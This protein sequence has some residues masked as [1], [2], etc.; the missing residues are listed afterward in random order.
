MEHIDIDKLKAGCELD[1]LVAIN[2]FGWQWG[3]RADDQESSYVALFQPG[4][5]GHG[6][7]I[8]VIANLENYIRFADWDHGISAYSTHIAAFWQVVE[9]LSPAWEIQFRWQPAGWRADRSRWAK[10]N[11]LWVAHFTQHDWKS[12]E[13][14]HFEGPEVAAPTL[15]LAGCRAALKAVMDVNA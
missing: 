3:R 4:E 8:P 7:W 5:R 13:E 2:L 15:P 12:R 6:A 1:A 14:N 11:G 10:F 9:H